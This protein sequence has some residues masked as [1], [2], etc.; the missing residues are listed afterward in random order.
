MLQKATGQRDLLPA[1]ART[2]ILVSTAQ[3]LIDNGGLQY[4]FE[5]N[6]EDSTPYEDF[7]DAYRDIGAVDAAALLREAVAMFPFPVPHLHAEQRCLRLEQL[8]KEND[9]FA[10]LDSKLCGDDSVW[11]RLEEFALKHKKLISGSL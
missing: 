10:A 7:C 2:I 1:P 6:F 3:G 9:R 5:S 11:E 8:W 4:F